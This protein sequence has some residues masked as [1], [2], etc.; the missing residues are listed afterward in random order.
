MYHC[1]STQAV[2]LELYIGCIG[3]HTTWSSSNVSAMF[4]LRHHVK[5]HLSVFADFWK[6]ILKLKLKKKNSGE[7]EKD[8]IIRVRVG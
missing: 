4:K 2:K 6:L 7:Q 3:T 8:S 1:Y 5:L